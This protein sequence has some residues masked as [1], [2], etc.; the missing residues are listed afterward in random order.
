M[1]LMTEDCQPSVSK[2]AAPNAIVLLNSHRHS[3]LSRYAV[4]YTA[5]IF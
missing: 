4:D 5:F 2:S 3:I 1:I